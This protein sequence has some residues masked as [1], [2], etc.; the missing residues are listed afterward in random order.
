MKNN[1]VAS[2]LV[3]LGAANNQE[4]TMPSLVKTAKIVFCGLWCA[5][6]GVDLWQYSIFLL[7]G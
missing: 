7:L 6:L 4:T 1:K 2:K 5:L 3:I